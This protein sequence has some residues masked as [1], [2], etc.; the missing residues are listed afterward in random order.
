M[1][2]TLTAFACAVAL[3][4]VPMATPAEAGWKKFRKQ[5]ANSNCWGVAVTFGQSK[6]MKESCRNS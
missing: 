5:M 1:K 4:A 6:K 3:A 2:V